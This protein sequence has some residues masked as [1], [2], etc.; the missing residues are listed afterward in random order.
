MKKNQPKFIGI[1]GSG[2]G[3]GIITSLLAVHP[4]V[5]G[6]IPALNFFNDVDYNKK[7]LGWY[8]EKMLFNTSKPL[9]G[10]CSPDY[11]RDENVALN[12]SKNYP[13]TK[14]FVVVRNPIDRAIAE[15]I[16]KK[17]ANKISNKISCARFLV[18]S[19]TAQ[20]DGFYGRNLQSYFG[21]YSP[22][23][24]YV[25]VYEDF[26]AEPLKQIQ[27]LYD[28][29]GLDKKFIPKALTRFA[30]P[31][32]EP[33]NPGKIKRLFMF[34]SRTLARMLP[35]KAEVKI[36]LPNINHSKFLSKEEIEL[37]SKSFAKDAN[38]L[39]HL[40]HRDMAVFWNLATESQ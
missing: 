30:P 36:F 18:E 29:L 26:V 17:S 10:E 15:Y 40:I 14:L 1:G 20:T 8:E 21:Y 24:L 22:L 25:L 16:Q 33:V 11:L 23:Q 3:L 13:D 9:S 28:F 7:G 6:K 38:Q 32:D 35:K 19:N 5:N 31:P 4:Q 39:S 37:F 34:I 2:T 27:S 12:I